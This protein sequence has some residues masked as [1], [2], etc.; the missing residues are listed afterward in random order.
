V[1]GEGS[2]HGGIEETGFALIEGVFSE[3]AVSHLRDVLQAEAT[4]AA[5]RGGI[6]H[7]LDMVQLRELAQSG[8][9]P[10]KVSPGARTRYTD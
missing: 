8:R 3:A 9:V 4:T 7:L 2:T 5:G 1:K 10:E 6:R